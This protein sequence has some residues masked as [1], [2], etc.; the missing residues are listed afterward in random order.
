MRRSQ[1]YNY[2]PLPQSG[3][4]DELEAEN[5]KMANELKDKIGALKSLTIDIGNYNHFNS[6]IQFNF[7]ITIQ[8]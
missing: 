2:D 1:G 6:E 3:N 5:E 4:T 8:F 7:T